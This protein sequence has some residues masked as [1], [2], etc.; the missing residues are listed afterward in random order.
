MILEH[1]AYLCNGLNKDSWITIKN[2]FVLSIEMVPNG[3][4]KILELNYMI[5][6]G[7]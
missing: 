2:Y 5:F 4:Q 6:T 1:P 3:L 7:V